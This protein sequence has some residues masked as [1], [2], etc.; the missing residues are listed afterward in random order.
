MTSVGQKAREVHEEI[1]VQRSRE[2][3]DL[4]A[5]EVRDWS[6]VVAREVQ[7]A[8]CREWVTCLW[9]ESSMAC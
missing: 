4:T 3:Q 1:P 9:S 8:V 7:K 2:T 5:S 6:Q